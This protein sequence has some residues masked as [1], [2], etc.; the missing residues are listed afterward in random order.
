MIKKLVATTIA[1]LAMQSDA[2]VA[3]SD[4]LM[5]AH[6]QRTLLTDISFTGSRLVAVGKYGTIVTSSDGSNWQQAQVPVQ[7]LLTAVTFVSESKG[8]A[9]GHDATILNTEDGGQ[10]WQIQQHLPDIEKPCLDITFANEQIGYAVGAYGM[11]YE[12]TDG[13]KNWQKRFIDAFVHPDDIE[14]LAELKEE[15]PVAY[16]DETAFILPHFNSLMIDGSDHYLA[17]EMGLF[18]VSKDAGKS[19]Q[20][21]PSFYAGSLFSVNKTS[22]GRVL[23]A[24]L[25]GNAFISD[26]DLS[27]F[28]RLALSKTTTINQV[29]SVEKQ[30]Y[31]FANSGVIFNRTQDGLS[32][33][34]LKNGKSIMAGVLF[35]GKL[36]LATE[37]GIQI[38]EAKH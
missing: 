20:R 14:Y 27:S 22:D 7:S 25:R 15:D 12:T 29:L 9:C 31:L 35:N 21:M 10:S 19:W 26:S 23:T 1:V 16:E 13:G 5:V 2:V 36:V 11:M 37:Q 30:Q 3:A 18:A 33:K 4:A 6:P 34:Q 24:G 32:S 17:G 8:W 38:V 28:N